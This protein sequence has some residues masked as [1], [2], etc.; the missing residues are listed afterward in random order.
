MSASTGAAGPTRGSV[1][2][3][4]PSLAAGTGAASWASPPSDAD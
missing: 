1:P 4:G 2:A 3:S